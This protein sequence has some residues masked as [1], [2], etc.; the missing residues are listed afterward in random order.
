MEPVPERQLLL[1][2]CRIERVVDIEHHRRGRLDVAGAIDIHHLAPDTDQRAQVRRILPTR[3]RRL[4]GEPDRLSGSLAERHH[5]GRVVPQGI[6]IIGVFVPTG[7]GQHTCPENVRDAVQYTRRVP[8][9]RD[10]GG[11]AIH[12]A[13]PQF[14][15]REQQNTGIRRDRSTVKRGSDFLRSNGW[16]RE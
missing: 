5:E 15:L 2:V 1:A 13:K 10:Q 3:H 11:D 16:K 8:P 4:T 14:G 12:D 9:I 7:D 6:E